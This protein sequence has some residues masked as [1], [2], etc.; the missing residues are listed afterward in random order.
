MKE[1]KVQFVRAPN[2][3][4]WDALNDVYKNCAAYSLIPAVITPFIKNRELISKVTDK[5]ALE[6]YMGILARDTQEY[7]SR[8]ANI[9][10]QHKHRK[11]HSADADDMMASVQLGEQY[12]EWCGSFESVILPTMDTI[13]DLLTTSGIDTV[14]LQV[15]RRLAPPM[16]SGAD[17]FV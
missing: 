10:D 7:L 6:K 15:P 9:H 8:L 3:H 11:G 4:A 12:I 16:K 13:R 14:E 5:T 17:A 2:D 1:K